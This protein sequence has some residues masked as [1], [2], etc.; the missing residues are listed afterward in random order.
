MD[1]EAHKIYLTRDVWDELM[2][3]ANAQGKPIGDVIASLIYDRYWKVEERI[4]ERIEERVEERVVEREGIAPA[5]AMVPAP[6]VSTHRYGTITN[7]CK[8]L[9]NAMKVRG[10]DMRD[11]EVWMCSCGYLFIVHNYAIA[12][13]ICIQCGNKAQYLGRLSSFINP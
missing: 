11:I 4:E 1:K 10:K 5:N 12:P 2:R 7:Y 8:V 3:L 13:R 9:A 6:C